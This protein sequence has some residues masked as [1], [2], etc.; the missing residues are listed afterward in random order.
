MMKNRADLITFIETYIKPNG[1]KEITGQQ[2]QDSLV[3]MCESLFNVIDE[4]FIANGLADTFKGRIGTDGQIQNLTATQVKIILQYLAEQVGYTPTTNANWNATIPSEVQAGLDQLAARMRIF[5]TN[6]ASNNTVYVSKSGSDVVGEF[7]VGNPLK[8]FLTITAG[9][10]AVP[11]SGTLIVDGGTYVENLNFEKSNFLLIMQ[12]VTLTG[13]VTST[14]GSNRTAILYNS[15]FSGAVRLDRFN[16]YGG[17]FNAGL[18]VLGNTSTTRTVISD[19]KINKTTT[20]AI[21]APFSDITNCNL[22]VTTGACVHGGGQLNANYYGCTLNG[23]NAFLPFSGDSITCKFYNCNLISTG[24]TIP[25]GEISNSAYFVNCRIESTTTFC[26]DFKGAANKNY[27]KA[28]IFKSPTSTLTLGAFNLAREVDTQTTFEECRF[29]A[30]TGNILVESGYSGEP[31]N[32]VTLF[33]NCTIN[34]ANVTSGIPT[35]KVVQ[36]NTLSILNL[37]D[38]N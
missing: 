18:S 19:A 21:S 35:A 11:I 5:E 32:A 2:L 9:I 25:Q 7:E 16:I 30:G 36:N 38:I 28:C 3:D 33:N 4:S 12:N 29:I 14:L 13:T 34:K 1:L 23:V 6:N 20:N 31:S 37:Q 8:P 10:N 15:T 26:V 27:F 22:S 17:T 24:I